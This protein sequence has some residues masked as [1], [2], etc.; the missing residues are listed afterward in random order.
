MSGRDLAGSMAASLESMA[1]GLRERDRVK[2]V[3]GRYI[4]TQV[5][6]KILKGDVNLGGEAR[7]VT[8]L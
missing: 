5:S 4:A 8:I 6:E 3:F 1:T 2:E 7:V